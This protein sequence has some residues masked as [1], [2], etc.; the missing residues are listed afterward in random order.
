MICSS[1]S[2]VKVLNFI[3]TAGSLINNDIKTQKIPTTGKFVRT[4]SDLKEAEEKG[5]NNNC[6]SCNLNKVSESHYITKDNNGDR[7]IPATDN[8]IDISTKCF[9]DCKAVKPITKKEKSYP[10]LSFLE[11]FQRNPD[12]NKFSLTKNPSI[13][14]FEK[15]FIFFSGTK[16]IHSMRLYF[17]LLHQCN[18]KPTKLI[19]HCI[20][21]AENDVAMKEKYYREM[22]LTQTTPDEFTFDILING[23]ENAGNFTSAEVY[24]K[25][26]DVITYTNLISWYAEAR[27]LAK[28][29]FYYNQMISHFIVPK[30]STVDFLVSAYLDNNDLEN[31][32]TVLKQ[33]LQVLEQSKSIDLFKNGKDYLKFY[34]TLNA[35][36]IKFPTTL[37]EKVFNALRQFE[38][39]SPFNKLVEIIEG[40]IFN[41]FSNEHNLLL[42]NLILLG[43]LSK[44]EK[45]L[46]TKHLET[47]LFQ[48]FN[49]IEMLKEMIRF[50]STNANSFKVNSLNDIV[51]CLIKFFGELDLHLT[52]ML[53]N[54]FCENRMMEEAWFHYERMLSN[55]VSPSYEIYISLFH[56]FTASNDIENAVKIKSLLKSI[57]FNLNLEGFNRILQ[58]AVDVSRLDLIKTFKEEMKVLGY[59][60]NCT[61]ANSMSKIY[62]ET[63]DLESQIDLFNAYQTWKVVMEPEFFLYCGIAA[64]NSLNWTLTSEVIKKLQIEYPGHDY[65]IKIVK[66]YED[67]FSLF[68]CYK[69]M[70]ISG[71]WKI[72]NNFRK[73]NRHPTPKLH[74]LILTRS[75]RSSSIDDIESVLDCLRDL[76]ECQ[77]AKLSIFDYEILI[78]KLILH[79]NV[80]LVI[81]TMLLYSKHD[82]NM[83][84]IQNNKTLSYLIKR[85]KTQEAEL[86]F[87]CMLNVDTV[88]FNTM[89]S[90]FKNRPI[91]LLENYVNVLKKKKVKL[92]TYSYTELMD[93]FFC[94]GEYSKVTELFNEMQ[95]NGLQPAMPTFGVLVK[96]QLA[97]NNIAGGLK[98][99][100]TAQSQDT[101]STVISL[102]LMKYFLKMQDYNMVKFIF[103]S[104]PESDLNVQLFTKM[105]DSRAKLGDA[106]AAEN[107]FDAMVSKGFSPD[108]FT[109]NTLL[110][111]YC[112]VGNEFKAVKLVQKIQSHF[113]LQAITVNLVL[114][115]YVKKVD[116]ISALKWIK[117]RKIEGFTE[118]VLTY[119]TLMKLYASLGDLKNLKIYH[120]LASEKMKSAEDAVK[121]HNHFNAIY[122]NS[123]FLNCYAKSNSTKEAIELFE[124]LEKKSLTPTVGMCTSLIEAVGSS[125]KFDLLQIW[126]EKILAKQKVQ[127]DL[128]FFNTLSSQFSKL[129][130]IDVGIKKIF[131][132]FNIKD[133]DL[134]EFKFFG[135][136]T[137]NK[138]NE[139]MKL[140]ARSRFLENSI[141][142]KSYKFRNVM[143]EATVF[144]PFLSYY[145]D[146][147]NVYN[148]YR[149]LILMKKLN[150]KPNV[151]TWAILIKGLALAKKHNLSFDIFKALTAKESQFLPNFP[152][153]IE[154]T[155][156]NELLIINVL[157]S[158]KFGRLFSEAKIIFMDC[159]NN[160]NL[161]LGPN[162]LTTYLEL[163]CFA[164]K[165]EEAFDVCASFLHF[166]KN[167]NEYLKDKKPDFFNF[168]NVPRIKPDLKT[169]KNLEALL[170]KS[171]KHL[172]LV[173]IVKMWKKSL[174]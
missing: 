158:L 129:H 78:K 170:E 76:L 120:K 74:T 62:F 33:L 86:L 71:T 81:K 7:N 17:R 121:Y 111:V 131:E 70:D 82:V 95:K 108:L 54:Y 26:L 152:I 11:N 16:D 30:M 68:N 167:S 115:L 161:S 146:S 124:S 135:S 73:Q 49:F 110:S 144:N 31:S 147:A 105:I 112:E 103:E 36:N 149:V 141:T 15:A 4:F 10:N 21:E 153:L 83:T 97:E 19:Y 160:E 126:T 47:V 128:Q 37:L 166:N 42:K 104:I 100:R 122:I 119:L 164:Q 6:Y 114:L 171:Q 3:R 133:F 48:N 140:N 50:K 52:E 28:V 169:L 63:G 55:N 53:V 46:T 75:I 34:N 94:A 132:F 165:Y 102:E 174:F 139:I 155:V 22:I 27:N 123:M 88:T 113:G 35:L 14:D 90:C 65:L 64:I 138:F 87:G 159:V 25:K 91:F 154:P 84:S 106:T 130:K 32:A 96:S 45:L 93:S 29:R 39:L 72:Y 13:F 77:D 59:E 23:F 145:A 168:N 20:M 148:M 142:G 79:D 172:E 40:E 150:L 38:D 69:K 1:K 116:S 92:D 12:V 9:P 24:L 151:T 2:T 99:Y 156:V 85:K 41:G 61:V 89:L 18:L 5:N 127:L 44:L 117:E 51:L 125:F 118:D 67:N 143:L 8:V 80:D 137:G 134:S 157:D 173:N 107:Y 98:I 66:I 109:Y 163:L 136:P 57:G 101:N 60:P 162:F 56:G 58:L 43:D